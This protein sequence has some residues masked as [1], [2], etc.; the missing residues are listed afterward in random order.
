[1]SALEVSAP[2]IADAAL[3]EYFASR[4]ADVDAA[5]VDVRDGIRFLAGTGF[6]E[7]DLQASIET[8]ARVAR[9]DLASAFSAWAHRMATWYVGLSPANSPL[10]GLLPKLRIADVIGATALATGTARYLSGAPLPITFREADGELALAGRIP[11]ASNLL[12][13]FVAVTAAAHADDD[14]RAIVI[15]ITDRTPGVSVAPHPDLLA[16]QATG[17]STVALDGVRVPAGNVISEDLD[18]FVET[19][20]APFLLLQ[21][22]FCRGLAERALEE[23]G[24]NLR[25]PIGD[26]FGADVDRLESAADDART[27]LARL[28][29]DAAAG[30][31]LPVPVRD[32]LQLRLDWAGIAGEAVRIEFATAGG[33]AFMRSNATAR[34]LREAAFLPIQAPTEAQLR[35]TLSRSA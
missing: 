21:S 29:A 19:V 18:E 6:T 13:P 14:R 3:D 32:L 35:W 9:Y 2:P 16:L 25:G 12:P 31:R 23:A 10:R 30:G 27:R 24:A 22:A 4:A 1:V 34:R 28:A 33:R 8:V 7:A 20:I 15:A 5:R 17:S 11:W 26:A